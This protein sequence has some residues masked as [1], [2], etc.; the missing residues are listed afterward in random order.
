[1]S[2]FTRR[3]KIDFE[4]VVSQQR[5]YRPTLH[6][7]KPNATVGAVADRRMEARAEVCHLLS[8]AQNVASVLAR[9]HPLGA[10]KSKK[11]SP[12]QTDIEDGVDWAGCPPMSV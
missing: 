11:D 1:M 4:E 12:G 10:S 2:V 9:I 8:N 3:L 7:K 5:R 6:I